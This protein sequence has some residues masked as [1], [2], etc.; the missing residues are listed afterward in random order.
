MTVVRVE[1]NT[2]DF[3]RDSAQITVVYVRPE[4]QAHA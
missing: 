2:I 3:L 1:V 4:E